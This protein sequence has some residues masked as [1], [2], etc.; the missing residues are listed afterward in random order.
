MI[1]PAT[2]C[3]TQ[4]KAEPDPQA[5]LEFHVDARHLSDDVRVGVAHAV[6]HLHTVDNVAGAVAAGS[7]TALGAPV[8]ANTPLRWPPPKVDRFATA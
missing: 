4:S 1:R 5:E 8:M 6:I 7:A 3:L 2:L